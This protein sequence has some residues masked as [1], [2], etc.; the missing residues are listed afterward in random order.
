MLQM[1]DSYDKPAMRFIYEAMNWLRRR[2]KMCSMVSI[3]GGVLSPTLTRGKTNVV[4]VK[5]WAILI[6]H[7][8]RGYLSLQRT[9]KEKDESSTNG[10]AKMNIW[11]HKN[12]CI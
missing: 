3:E 5:L 6:P 11:P 2:N 10:N 8:I 12:D 1:V 7:C 4:A 9:T